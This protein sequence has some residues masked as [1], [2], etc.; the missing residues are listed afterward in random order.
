MTGTYHTHADV[1]KLMGVALISTGEWPKDTDVDNETSQTEG[2]V[3]SAIYPFTLADANSSSSTGLTASLTRYTLYSLMLD[4]RWRRARGADSSSSGATPFSGPDQLQ[5]AQER[6]VV[7]IMNLSRGT[8][9][10]DTAPMIK[11]DE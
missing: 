4:D 10:W 7:K 5:T 9:K 11:D 1:E 3:E 6:L 2:E 8:R